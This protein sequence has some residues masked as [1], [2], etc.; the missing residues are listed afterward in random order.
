MCLIIFF[1][2]HWFIINNPT[3]KVPNICIY[4]V[5]YQSK[6][7]INFTFVLHLVKIEVTK[8]NKLC[9]ITCTY[10]ILN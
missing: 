2:F 10:I 9:T 3:Q 4:L 5:F 8:N 7:A 1:N 6:L